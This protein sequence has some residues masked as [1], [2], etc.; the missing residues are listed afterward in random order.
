MRSYSRQSYQRLLQQQLSQ[1][2][3]V[4]VAVKVEEMTLADRFTPQTHLGFG[5]V[6]IAAYALLQLL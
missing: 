1:Q 3:I 2:D 5:L 6:T 4:K